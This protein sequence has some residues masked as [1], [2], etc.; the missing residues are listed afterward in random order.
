MTGLYQITKKTMAI[1]PAFEFNYSSKV[2]E[3][4]TVKYLDESPIHIIKSNCLA[5]GASYEGRKKAVIHHLSFH[6]KTPIPIYLQHD[7]YAFPTRSPQSIHCSWLFHHTIRK[8]TTQNK[9]TLI[10]FHNGQQL[11]VEDSF[12]SIKKQYDRTG[13]CRAVFEYGINLTI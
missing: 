10:I 9:H 4:D 11:Q 8:I 6:Q 5:G 2:L 12:Y 13:M 7:I 1:M 3:T